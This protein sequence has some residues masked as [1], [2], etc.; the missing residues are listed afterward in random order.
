MIVSTVRRSLLSMAPAI[1][2]A[3]ASTAAADN[4]PSW[5]GADDSGCAAK[6][7]YPVA[8]GAD[9]GLVWKIPLPGKGCSTPVVWEQRIF[10]TAPTDGNDSVIAYDWN[11]EIVW[12]HA[13]GPEKAGRH[14]N[15]SGSNPSP[16]TDGRLIFVLF[17]SG[18][19]AAFT[20]DGAMYWSTNLHKRFGEGKLFWDF[21]TSPVVTDGFVIVAVMHAGESYVVAFEKDT[22]ALAWK[23]ARNYETPVEGDHGYT[24]PLVYRDGGEERVL[25]WGA[26]HLTEHDA[27]DGKIVWSCGGF[28]TEGT[29]NWVPVA[30]AVIA[31]GMAVVP[32]G[33]G[34]RLHGVKIGGKGDVTTTNRK[35]KRD[36]TGAFVPTPAVYEGHV[37]LL[38]DEGEVQRVDPVT[39][40]TLWRADLPKGKGKFYASPV[41]ADGKLYTAR[42]NGI[43]YV[44]KLGK[45][46]EPLSTNDMG[47][48]VIASPVPVDG[49]LLIRG[50]KHLFC[51]GAS[52]S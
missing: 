5:R 22:G 37:V 36:D 2:I 39:G 8:F 6:G 1:L 30:S 50:S 32:Y 27:R 18:D 9:S 12:R 51:V 40:A 23:V 29:R 10:V 49:R 7:A 25:V 4:W 16:V 46:L 11:G 35:W 38:R 15:G 43:V 24:T 45:G 31:N 26:I 21:G 48:Q 20:L 44:S 19:L 33:R 28:N 52:G 41:I 17:K 13:L 3:L 47:E 14:K 42:E 34:T